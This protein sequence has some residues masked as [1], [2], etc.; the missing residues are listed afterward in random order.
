MEGNHLV[1]RLTNSLNV[2]LVDSTGLVLLEA[3]NVLFVM[4]LDHA[5]LTEGPQEVQ[6]DLNHSVK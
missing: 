2:L 6:S 4:P 5:S 3:K 1:F